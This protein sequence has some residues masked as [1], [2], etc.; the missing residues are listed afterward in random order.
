MLVLS[1]HIL[2]IIIIM[3]AMMIILEEG[4]RTA[5][6]TASGFSLQTRL[7]TPPG[8]TANIILIVIIIVMAMI[9]I[10]MIIIEVNTNSILSKR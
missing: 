7:D 8:R 9:V 10:I 6:V 1:Y 3:I 5:V 4:V 2:M